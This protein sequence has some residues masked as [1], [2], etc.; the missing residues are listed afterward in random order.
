MPPYVWISGEGLWRDGRS[1]HFCSTGLPSTGLPSFQTL[2]SLTTHTLCYVHMLMV[3][4]GVLCE[5]V[6]KASAETEPAW[7][8]A[9]AGVGI[10]VWRIVK[11]KVGIACVALHGQAS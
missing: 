6:K 4:V 10:Q 2:E 8:G 3:Y 9:G 11:F 5:Q 7:N 1:L